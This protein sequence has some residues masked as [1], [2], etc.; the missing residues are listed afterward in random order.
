[1][2]CLYLFESDHFGSQRNDLHELFLTKLTSH[3][4][5]NAGPAG[6]VLLIDDDHS[7]AVKA[8]IRAVTTTH[9]M[10]GADDDSIL[11]FTL[12]DGPI[13]SC[14]LDMDLITSPTWA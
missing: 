13:R 10:S 12:F 4:S 9:R 8:N 14:L 5:E 11:D 3:R 6:I 2:P 1:M 7:V